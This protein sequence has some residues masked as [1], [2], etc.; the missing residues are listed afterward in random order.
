MGGRR[1]RRGGSCVGTEKRRLL[2]GRRGGGGNQYIFIY[3]IAGF[4]HVLREC[5]SGSLLLCCVF[6]VRIAV[7]W[8]ST[9]FPPRHAASGPHHNAPLDISLPCGFR[10]LK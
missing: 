3:M 2:C 1:R 7:L 10:L 4:Y 5:R 9:Q 6:V 8:L